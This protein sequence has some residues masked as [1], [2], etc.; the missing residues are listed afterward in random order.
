MYSFHFQ[1]HLRV[2]WS[3]A[4]KELGLVG[5]D[6]SLGGGGVGFFFIAFK[7]YF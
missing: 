5:E 1:V 3:V 6:D 7:N 4:A 2:C